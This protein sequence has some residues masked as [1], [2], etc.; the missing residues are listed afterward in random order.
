MLIPDPDPEAA[1]RLRVKLLD[2]GI[3]K[4]AHEVAQGSGPQTSADVVMGTPKYMS[5]EQCRGAGNVDDKSDVYALG[6]M[7]YEMLAGRVP[8]IGGTGEI[9][10]KQIYEEPAPLQRHAPHVSERLAA[11]VHRLLQKNKADRPAMRQVAQELEQMAVQFPTTMHSIVALPKPAVG[12][13]AATVAMQAATESGDD[14]TPTNP[15]IAAPAA[16]FIQMAQSGADSHSGIQ[17]QSTLGFSV[18]QSSLSMRPH[19]SRRWIVGAIGGVVALA[20]VVLVLIFRGDPPPVEKPLAAALR[21]AKKKVYWAV[22]S[23][24]AGAEIVRVSDGRVLG[25]TPWR[26]EQPQGTG[27]VTLRLRFVGYQ[28]R[29]VDL[30]SN[31]DDRSEVTLEPVP[32]L[33]EGPRTQRPIRPRP[34]TVTGRPNS[35]GKPGPHDKPKIVD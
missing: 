24:P 21:P 33:T 12:P 22:S 18:G 3:A 10:A 16:Q 5:P 1:G 17:P 14:E 30:D 6:V 7:M 28:D 29:V 11:L 13:H 23:S 20:A 26:S 15:S 35:S 8:F 27:H 34:P 2:F 9:L 31:A 32:P 25:K 4:V 19:R